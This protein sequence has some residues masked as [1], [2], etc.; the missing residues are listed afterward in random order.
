MAP[1]IL[2]VQMAVSLRPDVILLD[3]SMPVIGGV[4]AVLRIA[5]LG[6]H[7]L[8]CPTDRARFESHGESGNWGLRPGMRGQIEHCSRPHTCY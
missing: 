6:L 1:T 7:Q 2:A 3:V 4:D 5:E 8:R